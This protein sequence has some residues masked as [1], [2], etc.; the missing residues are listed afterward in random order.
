MTGQPLWALV[1][2]A[3]RVPAAGREAIAA[4]LATSGATRRGHVLVATCHRIELLGAGPV[5]PCATSMAGGYAI[6]G[7]PSAPLLLEGADAVRHLCRLAA[8]LESAV[9]GEDQVLHQVRQALTVARAGRPPAELVR[10]F[11]VAIRVGRRARAGNGRGHADLGAVAMTW[12]EGVVGPLAGRRVVVAGAGAMGRDLA[13]AAGRQGADVVLASRDRAH[14][15]RVASAVGG[16]ATDLVAALRD[17]ATADALAIA[18]PGPWP[19]LD[20]IA[21]LPPTVDLSFP[22]V[23]GEVHRADLGTRHADVD[24]LYRISRTEADTDTTIDYVAR[25]EALVD[26]AVE[27]Y[28]AWLAARGSVG[29]LRALRDRA[30]DLRSRE[31]ERLLR[32]LPGLE[33]HERHLLAE[34]S[35]QLVATMLHEPTS[36]LRE[37][38]DGSAAT[39]ARRLFRL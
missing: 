33:P 16:S 4:N 10:A 17:V 35:E 21:L 2:S 39:A 31:L 38:A 9:V 24:T 29:T 7:L 12:L 34:F 14:A 22:S 25:A 28:A 15:V 3:D 13:H 30:E 27:R 1:A 26:E 6:P 37:D 20:G 11:E 5:D 23:V 32:R 8:G 36:V 19:G 18:L